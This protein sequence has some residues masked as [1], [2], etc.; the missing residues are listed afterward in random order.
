MDMYPKRKNG[1]DQGNKRERREERECGG[2]GTEGRGLGMTN[3]GGMP[4]R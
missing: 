3:R 4:S 2:E 1:R